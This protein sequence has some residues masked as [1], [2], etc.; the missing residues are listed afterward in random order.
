MLAFFF[1]AVRFLEA[2]FLATF[3]F[4]RELGFFAPIAVATLFQTAPGAAVTVVAAAW[5]NSP[6]KVLVPSAAVFPAATTVTCA[7]AALSRTAGTAVAVAAE[8]ALAASPARALAR[9]AALF[10]AATTV[11]CARVD[12]LTCHIPLSRSEDTHK[13]RTRDNQSLEEVRGLCWVDSNVRFGS[14]ADILRCGSNVR[15]TPKSG[16]VR[17]K[18]K[19]PLCANSGHSNY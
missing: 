9:L 7:L 1:S 19:C 11:S 6:T 2:T 10:S 4:V 14:L 15:F 18:S 13:H 16:H 3:F 12:A 17:C 5:A 8:A